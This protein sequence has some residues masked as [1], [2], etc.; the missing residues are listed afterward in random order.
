[1]YALRS[2]QTCPG[3]RAHLKRRPVL[4]LSSAALPAVRGAAANGLGGAVTGPAGDWLEGAPVFFGALLWGGSRAGSRL[5]RDV[6][7]LAGGGDSQEKAA[8][9]WLKDLSV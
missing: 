1:M 8:G 5:G 6:E 9:D 7:G 2:S 3:R 4:P